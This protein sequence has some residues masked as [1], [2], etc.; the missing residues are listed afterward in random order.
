MEGVTNEYIGDL[1]KRINGFSGREIFKMVVAW[2]DAAFSKP[3]PVLT[4]ELMEEILEKF[5]NQHAQKE[6]W[7]K[8]EG[9]LFEKML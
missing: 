4:P 2:H 5:K 6:K 1:A 3:D 9:N 8:K 7:S